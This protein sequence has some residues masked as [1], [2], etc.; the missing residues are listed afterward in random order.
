MTTSTSTSGGSSPSRDRPVDAEGGSK[1]MAANRKK[2]ERPA[3]RFELAAI[4]MEAEFTVLVDGAAV[5]PEELFGDPR[6]FLGGSAM[7]RRGRSYHL[8]TG[9]AVYF[10]TGV[11]EV[12]TPLIEIERG[13]GARAGRSLWEGIRHVRD[14]LDVWS[15]RDGRD[16]RLMGFSAHYN[17]SFVESGSPRDGRTID[18]LA[19]LLVRILP[20]PVML[21]AANR[22]S[23]GVGVRPRGDRIEITVDFTPSPSL[24]IATA[25]LVTAITRAVM[26][27]PSYAPGEIRR[28]GIPVPIGLAPVP[29]TSRV[30]L[31]AHAD[32][33][34]TNPF[35]CD[36]DER[37][38]R[39]VDGRQRSL[40]SIARAIV[41]RFA[42]SIR[43]V[44]DPFTHR[45]IESVVSGRAPA[46][47]DLDDRPGEY[48]DVG[49]LCRW[50]DL[51]PAR[52]LAR[53]RYERVLIRAIAGDRLNVH[54]RWYRP[55][56]MRGWSEVIFRR[57]D[58]RSRHAFAIDVLVAKL[59]DWGRP[60]E[61]PERRHGRTRRSLV[62]R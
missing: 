61:A 47:L 25:T 59:D 46:L 11:L 57:E 31:L 28:R 19:H 60:E 22:R 49:R 36:P 58:D 14:A 43:A 38:W 27:W 23:T 20:V 5:L 15:A 34:P 37:I 45:L 55:V 42:R 7:H 35:T 39:T 50:D 9:G 8:P 44:S 10:D 4:G 32:S 21:L 41:H 62:S 17:V 53:S 54:G 33:F 13:C 56:G 3:G 48:E 6:A 16:V 24:M 52:S 29:H 12:A 1:R 40:R 51:H 2:R 26:R 18:D 30:G